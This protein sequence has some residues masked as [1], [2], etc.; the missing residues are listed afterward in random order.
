MQADFKTQYA[1]CMDLLCAYF[2]SRGFADPKFEASLKFGEC[3]NV[4]EWVGFYL[5]NYSLNPYATWKKDSEFIFSN[6]D[7]TKNDVKE[8]G[9]ILASI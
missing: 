3:A 1:I 4:G 5:T 2:T 9:S 8:I 6:S 7:L